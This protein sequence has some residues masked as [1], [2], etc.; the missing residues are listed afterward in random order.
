M[1]Q[2]QNDR[3]VAGIITALLTALILV[4][5]FVGGM[6]FDRQTLAESSTPEIQPDEEYFIEPLPIVEDPGEPDIDNSAE[7]Q[8][9]APTEQGE[10]EPAPVENNK[11]VVNGEN[12]KQPPVQRPMPVTQTKESPVK[13]VPPKK[14]DK[15][16]SKVTSKVANAFSGKNGAVGGKPGGTGTGGTGTASVSGSSRGRS[17]LGCPKPDVAIKQ[18][19]V[20][21]VNVTINEAGNVV[22]AHATGGAAQY[23]RTACEQAARHARWTP[24][25]GAGTVAGVITFTIT[26]KM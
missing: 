25:K 16:D 11:V 7:Q 5:L 8:E 1:K 21:S 9:E 10:P 23:L 2:Q 19:V 24:M 20:I 3:L 18:R 13:V 15:P 26:P 12:T 4:G 22:S 14:T 17:M 6:T